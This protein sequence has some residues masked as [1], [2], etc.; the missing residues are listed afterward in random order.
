MHGRAYLLLAFL[1]AGCAGEPAPASNEQ[2]EPSMPLARGF[3]PCAT[4]RIRGQVIWD[5][6]VPVPE[7]RSEHRYLHLPTMRRETLRFTLPHY[8]Q[9]A[10][11]SGGLANAVVF[12][13][14]I[15]PACSKPWDHTPVQV[16][17]RDQ[18]LAILQGSAPGPVGFVRRGDAVHLAN[19]DSAYHLLRGDGAAFFSLPLQPSSNPQERLFG[20]AGLVDLQCV[21]G[22]YWLRAHL[23]VADH[24]YYARTDADGRFALEDVPA[25]DYTVVCWVP[26]WELKGHERNPELATIARL[27]WRPAVEQTRSL[28]VRTRQTDEVE[29]R[30]RASMFTNVAQAAQ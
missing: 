24:P 30:V 25:G 18:Q 23:F 26:N 22:F 20:Q 13:R 6:E 14:G 1:L 19:R 3:N 4:G 28:R 17:F 10:S 7:M 5:G 9:V 27:R 15:D 21:A 16:E 12:L 11:E 8:P 2:A 29:F